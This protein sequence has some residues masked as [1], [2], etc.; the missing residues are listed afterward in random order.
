MENLC[1]PLKAE[2]EYVLKQFKPGDDVPFGL[3]ELD[4]VKAHFCLSDYFLSTGEE[5]RYGILNYNMLSS[6]VYRQFVSFNGNY[7]WESSYDRMA[8][9]MYGLTMD[10]AF[11][12]GNKRTALLSMLLFLS[13]ENRTLKVPKDELELLLVRI[14]GGQLNLYKEY[15]KYYQGKDDAEIRFISDKIKHC[16]RKITNASHP[17]TYAEFNSN[18]KRFHFWMDNPS[19]NSITVYKESTETKT[20]LPFRYGRQ[21][22]KVVPVLKVGFPGW[23]KQISEKDVKHIL[24]E[25]GLTS[26][27]GFDSQ[28]F[29]DGAEPAYS[30]IQEYYKP[31]LRL[32]DQ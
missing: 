14:A 22:K 12:D 19:G 3:S 7:K 5:V 15:V 31:L 4:V 8:T 25:T 27:K 1:D 32:K 30:L 17:L 2:Y 29:Y 16:S 26:T 11:H 23:K 13:R 21:Q 18:L 24:K 6:A 10:H 28:V 9:L 20:F